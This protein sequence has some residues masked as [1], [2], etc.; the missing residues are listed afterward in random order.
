M[1]GAGKSIGW[2]AWH[3]THGFEVPREYEGAIAFADLDPVV[4]KVR[5][6]NRDDRTT[7]RTGWRA[8]KV[9]LLKVP[10]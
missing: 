2:A 1:A 10:A 7:N 9:A 3:P 6:L 4:R 8:V 5:D